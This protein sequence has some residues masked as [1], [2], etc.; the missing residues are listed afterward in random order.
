V[1]TINL[2]MDI[3]VI[4]IAI[5]LIIILLIP[6]AILFFVNKGVGALPGLMRRYAPLVQFRFRQATEI[7]EKASQKVAAPVIA[8]EAFSSRVQR[9]RRRLF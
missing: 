6:G 3:S 2:L 9:M 1:Q 4:I 7:A 5:P 8:A